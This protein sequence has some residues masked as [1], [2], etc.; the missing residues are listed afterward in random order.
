L[1]NLINV[2]EV[3]TFSTQIYNKIYDERVKNSK[4]I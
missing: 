2:E 1:D 3:T 4:N